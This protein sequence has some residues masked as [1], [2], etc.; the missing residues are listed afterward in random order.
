MRV[1]IQES[2]IAWCAGLFIGEGNVGRIASRTTS[3]TYEYLCLQI[4]MYDWRSIEKFADILGLKSYSYHHKQRNCVCWKVCAR[5]RTAEAALA[6]L[7]PFI[8]GTDKGDQAM[9]YAKYLGVEKWITGESVGVR[10]QSN[11]I[12]RGRKVCN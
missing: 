8:C 9:K 3:G 1:N 10:P 5:G 6:V 11:S 7:W 2:D 4:S 12:K